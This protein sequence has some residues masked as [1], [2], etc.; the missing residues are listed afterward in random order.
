VQ[1]VREAEEDI[2]FLWVVQIENVEGVDANLSDHG[3]G[4]LE[5]GEGG[6]G[7]LLVRRIGHCRDQHRG[8]GHDQEQQAAW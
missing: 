2:V 6:N 4:I 1:L 3:P 7:V 8:E 5:F